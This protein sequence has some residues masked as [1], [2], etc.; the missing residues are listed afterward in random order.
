MG[1]Q[2]TAEQPAAGE[3]TELTR[4]LVLGDAVGGGL[5]A[6]LERMAQAGGR[7]DVSIRF[8]EES[9]LAQARRL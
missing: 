9:G 5:G 6:G 7:F 3:A 1:S 8:N 4:M 2:A